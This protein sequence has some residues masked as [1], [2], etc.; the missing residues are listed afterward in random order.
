LNISVILDIAHR[1]G[2]LVPHVS[3]TESASAIKCK[4]SCLVA[5]LKKSCAQ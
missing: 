1:V 2:S 3:E 4:V 5:L